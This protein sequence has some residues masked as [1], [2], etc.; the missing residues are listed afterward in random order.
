MNKTS[1]ARAV[2]LL[3]LCGC[4]PQPHMPTMRLPAG[5]LPDG[6]P[7]TF[8]AQV[9][10]QARYGVVAE[11]SELTVK[12]YRAG[13]LATFGHNHVIQ[14]HI[15][16]FVYLA[17]DLTDA[18]ADLYV[19]VGDLVVDDAAARAAAGPDF[20]T[21]PSQSD[22]AGTRTNMLGPQVLDAEAAPFVTVHVTPIHVGA[23]TTQVQLSL[24]VR[25]HLA[26][27]PVDVTW[28]R[29]GDELSIRG[30]FSVDHATLGL[31][32]FSAFGGAIRVADRIDIVVSIVATKQ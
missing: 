16:G 25:G 11:R 7:T 12:V 28:H 31:A 20:A 8:Y 15:N 29:N 32:P 23:Q 27:V 10:A 14:G 30:A 19:R 26:R 5:G 24:N 13:A 6:F 3:V 2:L 18:R 21:Q 4:V 9:P 1:V 22:I 17:E